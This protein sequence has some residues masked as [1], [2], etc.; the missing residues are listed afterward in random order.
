LRA[1]TYIVRRTAL[2]I[3][4]VSDSVTI[5]TNTHPIRILTWAIPTSWVD[6]TNEPLARVNIY[7]IVTYDELNSCQ[8]ECLVSFVLYVWFF[9]VLHAMMLNSL[10]LYSYIN[11]HLLGCDS[12]YPPHIHTSF[13][14]SPMHFCSTIVHILENPNRIHRKIFHLTNTLNKNPSS[15]I[16][17]IVEHTVTL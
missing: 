15:V 4:Q 13:L 8:R 14:F 11:L 5:S 2:Q 7:G 16:G 9:C 6:A 10:P 1:A 17:Q 12:R 3:W